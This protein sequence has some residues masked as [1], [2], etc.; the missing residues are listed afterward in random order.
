[1]SNCDV[2]LSPIPVVILITSVTVVA[3]TTVFVFAIIEKRKELLEKRNLKNIIKETSK[4]TCILCL[5][6]KNII[7]FNRHGRECNNCQDKKGYATRDKKR[8]KDT[9]TKKMLLNK[10]TLTDVYLRKLI[11][12][13]MKNHGSFKKKDIP[14]QF[15][16]LKRKELLTKRKIQSWQKQKQ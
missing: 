7:C 4:K 9:S 14:Q 16:D 5:K 3:L 8:M 13:N 1:M 11:R 6:T 15:I 2:N 10:E 12:S